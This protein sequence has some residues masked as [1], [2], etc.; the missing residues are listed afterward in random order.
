[1][2][3]KSVCSF[4]LAACMLFGVTGCGKTVETTSEVVISTDGTTS[5]IEGQDGY[6]ENDSQSG[7]DNADG[8]G[9]NSSKN[10]GSSGGGN[11]GGATVTLSTWSASLEPAKSDPT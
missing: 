10:D 3:I 9:N 1:M 2:K 6:Y 7:A 4:L 8:N 5:V 11:T